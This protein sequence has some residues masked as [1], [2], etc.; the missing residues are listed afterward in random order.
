MTDLEDRLRTLSASTSTPPA[1]L[2]QLTARAGQLRRRRQLMQGAGSLAAVAMIALVGTNVANLPLPYRT[3]PPVAFEPQPDPV[4]EGWQRRE[5]GVLRIDHPK[6]WNVEL[7]KW[8][9]SAEPEVVLSN[10]RL[11]EADTELALLARDDVRFSADFPA[12]AVVFVVGGDPYR[13]GPSPAGALGDPTRLPRPRGLDGNVVARTGRVKQSILHLA[14][15]IGPNAPADDAK[16]L[17]D[18]AKSVVLGDRP[19]TPEDMEPPP[20]GGPIGTGGLNPDDPV[21]TDNWAIAAEV[22]LDDDELIRVRTQ[23][24]CAAVTHEEDI[25]GSRNLSVEH[26]ECGLSKQPK[27]ALEQV[28][29]GMFMRRTLRDLERMERH[30]VVARRA[31]GANVQAQLAGRGTVSVDDSNGWYIAVTNGRFFRLVATD[32]DGGKRLAVID[33]L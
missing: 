26:R 16:T 10:R 17:D 25:P 24:D 8:R 6:G 2:E 4:A 22:R 13:G 31:P 12:D 33:E 28:V 20:P 30:V 18:V 27:A 7:V 9:K 1:P 29:S 15:Y 19:L 23:G 21:F 3:D 11:T 32:E 5:I 14:A